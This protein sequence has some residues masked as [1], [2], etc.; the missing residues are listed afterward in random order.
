MPQRPTHRELTKKLG[1][2]LECLNSEN[3]SLV[4]IDRAST[5]PQIAT[6]IERLGLADDEAYWALV[7]RCL[8]LAKEDPE[9]SY[10]GGKPP[11]TCDTVR[12]LR[13]CE[14]F[15][16]TVYD[17]LTKKS[18]YTKFAIKKMHN[19]DLM[20]GHITCHKDEPK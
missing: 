20:Y 6:N 18:V 4:I 1:I 2:A 11:Q 15:A 9:G 10:R 12:I 3:R 17:E 16:F 14:M 19:G 8:T 7:T 13:N 5:K